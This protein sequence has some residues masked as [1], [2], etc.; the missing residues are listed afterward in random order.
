VLTKETTPPSRVSS[1]GGVGG[2]VSTEETPP[3][4]CV[5]SEGGG[6]DG[7]G[8]STEKPP[9]PSGVSSEG[10]VVVVCRQKEPLH[11]EGELFYEKY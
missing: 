3:P 10:G 6:G 1:E 8:V 7:G 9:P 11:R 5:S 4:S 2:G